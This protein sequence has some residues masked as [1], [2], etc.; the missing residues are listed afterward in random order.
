MKNVARVLLVIS[1]LLAI[2]AFA[3]KTKWTIDPVHTQATFQ[4][5]HLSVTTIRGSKSNV[6]GTVEWVPNDPTNS[7]DSISRVSSLVR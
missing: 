5:R 1:W 7:F 2:P 6:T 4:A 3:Q